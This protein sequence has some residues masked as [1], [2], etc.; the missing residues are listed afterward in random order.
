MPTEGQGTRCWE[1]SDRELSDLGGTHEMKNQA[2]RQHVPVPDTPGP[3]ERTGVS[4][5]PRRLLGPYHEQ[6][7]TT[8][9]VRRLREEGRGRGLWRSHRKWLSPGPGVSAVV[10]ITRLPGRSLGQGPIAW[11]TGPL[12]GGFGSVCLWPTDTPRK[13]E[14]TESCRPR[15]ALGA[16]KGLIPRMARQWRHVAL[17][18]GTAC[19]STAGPGIQ[20][21]TGPGPALP[22]REPLAV[23]LPSRD[24]GPQQGSPG[25]GCA[26][27]STQCGRP[28]QVPGPGRPSRMCAP[29]A[30]ARRQRTPRSVPRPAARIWG[31][32]GSRCCSGSL[33]PTG[34]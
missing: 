21:S 17:A 10:L 12:C 2:S 33:L 9:W 16:P 11:P 26:P 6:N 20:A 4:I 1:L 14:G 3:W 25:L 18:P 7:A 13:V 34:P 8:P 24:A 29:W 32:W 5:G 28:Q 30:S 27:G 31:C 19:P 15:S 22:E 23:D